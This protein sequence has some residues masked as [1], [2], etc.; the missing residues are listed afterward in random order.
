M[1]NKKKIYIIII[2]LLVLLLII[3]VST[4][5]REKKKDTK[6]YKIEA[7]NT[8]VLGD[9]YI[10]R[11]FVNI[12]NDLLNSEHCQDNICVSITKISCNENMGSIYYKITNKGNYD[13]DGYYM[14]N[15]DGN[16]FYLKYDNLEIG[17]S[18]ESYHNYKNINLTK[19]NDFKLSLLSDD[20][21]RKHFK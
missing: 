18:N 5:K 6:E 17:Q 7:S 15:L 11:S 19:I 14:I 21:G 1:N 10:D 8:I 4:F 3:I 9:D 16:K 12:T 20:E 2:L 13:K